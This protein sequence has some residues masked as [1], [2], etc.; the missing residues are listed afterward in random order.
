[1]NAM[2]RI[3]LAN[4]TT[5][6]QPMNRMTLEERMTT[7]RSMG[8]TRAWRDLQTITIISVMRTHLLL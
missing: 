3:R 1:M 6:T 2:A 4:R 8:Q 7:A 5:W